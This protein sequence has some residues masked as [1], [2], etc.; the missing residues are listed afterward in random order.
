MPTFHPRF[1]KLMQERY[2]EMGR[3]RA[4]LVQSYLA[5]FDGARVLDVGSGPNRWYEY[6][7]VR[8][9]VEKEAQADVQGTVEALPFRDGAFDVV[10]ATELIEHVRYP[11]TMLRE[12]HRVLR[13]GGE[14]LLSTPNAASLHTRFFLLLFGAFVPDRV[15]HDGADLGHLHFFDHDYTRKLLSEAGFEVIEDKS[16]IVHLG[17]LLLKEPRLIPNSLRELTIYRARKVPS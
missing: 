1:E 16:A 5:G 13:A 8:L 11:A 3:Y 7:V 12:V 4:R 17:R 6:P 10:I 9:D 2:L 15:D 14:L